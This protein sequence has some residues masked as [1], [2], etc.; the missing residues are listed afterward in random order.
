MKRL[1]AA[2]KIHPSE[3]FLLNFSSLRNSLFH[4]RITW[5]DPQNMHITLKFF[6]ETNE[7]LIPSIQ[8]ALLAACV[9]SGRFTMNIHRTG[10]FGSRYDPRVIWFGIDPEPGLEKLWKNLANGLLHAGW[11]SDRQNFV[12]HLTAGRIREIKDKILFQQIIGRFRDIQLHQE[13]ATQVVL[14]ESILNR[15]GPR[16]LEVATF[17]IL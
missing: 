12:P 13:T 3:E 4:E 2:I 1:F 9:N 7:S 6:G 10:I 14:F 11:E 15:D 5:V 17:E 8:D 16:Y